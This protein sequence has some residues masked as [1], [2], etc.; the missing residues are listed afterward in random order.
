MTSQTGNTGLWR[1]ILF[2]D[3]CGSTKLYEALGNTRAQAV[4][5]KTLTILSNIATEN[6]GTII[7]SIGDEVMVTFSLPHHAVDA[8]LGMHQALGRAIASG[9]L[10]VPKLQIRAGFHCGPVIADGADVFGDAVNVAARVA[11]HAK[12]GQILITQQTANRLPRDKAAQVRFI[13]NA[14]LKGKRESLELYEVVWETEGMTKMQEVVHTYSG[15]ARLTATFRTR[16]IE[17]T[18]QRSALS[19][20][21]VEGNDIVVVDPLVSRMHARIELRRGRFVLIDQSLNGT[22]VSMP[23][24]NEMAVRRDEL[25]LLG[26]GLIALGKSTSLQ[27][28]HCIGFSVHS[29]LPGPA[30]P[31]G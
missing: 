16:S 31:K 21:R 11:G 20:G 2:V 28:E 29:G 6:A 12:P 14:H 26:S 18:E 19:M 4:I 7:K 10:E 25:T 13:G 22:F 1:T 15:G 8:V 24:K 3:V 17:V 27:R 5:S 9:E 30:G 23:G